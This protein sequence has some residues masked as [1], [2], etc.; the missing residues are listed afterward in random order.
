MAKKILL[1]L[2]ICGLISSCGFQVIYREADAETKTSYEQELATIRIQKEGGRLTQE[3]R[4]ALK[5]SF[6]PDYIDAEPKYILT[7][8]TLKSIGGTFITVTGASGRNRITLTIDYKLKDASTGK[9]VSIGSTVVNDNYDVQLNRYGTYIA[10]DY[11]RSNLVKIAALNIRNLLVNDLIE[12]K[13]NGGKEM[14][15]PLT[16]GVYTDEKIKEKDAKLV[17][18]AG[19]TG[20]ELDIPE[21]LKTP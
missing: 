15:E 7:L 11:A 10:E 6:N 13:K 2:I 21:T 20:N 5:D 3:L 9:I 14:D 1:T 12:L 4:N 16:N 19:C 17:A 18:E 8:N